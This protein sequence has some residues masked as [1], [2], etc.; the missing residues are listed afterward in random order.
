MAQV[1]VALMVVATPVCADVKIADRS[2]LAT[3]RTPLATLEV[4]DQASDDSAVLLLRNGSNA[5]L[6]EVEADAQVGIKTDAPTRELDVNGDVRVRNLTSGYVCAQSDGTLSNGLVNCLSIVET[7]TASYTLTA[8]DN[9]KIIE[10]DSAT[11][12]TLTVPSG[13]PAGYEVSITQKGVGQVIFAGSGVTI[14]NAR[15][16]DR[17]TAQWAKAG[18]E[19]GNGGTVILS[20]D[21]F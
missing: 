6:M 18:I 2:I 13:L 3:Q 19:V 8:A 21:V 7:K 9:D 5:V 12:V 15:G 11:D 14:R 1:S 4:Q 20:G 17:T 16:Y 10:F